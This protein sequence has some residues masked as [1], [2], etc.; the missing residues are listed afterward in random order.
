[1]QA[2]AMILK[3]VTDIDWRQLEGSLYDLFGVNAVTL[4][5][6][7]IRR[8]SGDIRLA[9]DLCA[10]IKTHPN[11]ASRICDRILKILINETKAKK[12][13]AI[14]ECAAGMNKF[15]F[16]I[17]QNDELIGF[18]N[19]CG[20]PFLNTNRIYTDYIGETIDVKTDKI[21]K[22]SFTLRPIGP[23]TVKEMKHFIASYVN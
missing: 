20:R 14:D 22:L 1:M 4:K 21:K 7:G 9:N 8:T 5:K 11:G 19:I 18:I 12:T 23:R 6:N 2:K 13:L 3:E 17:I 16:P 15:V 10:L